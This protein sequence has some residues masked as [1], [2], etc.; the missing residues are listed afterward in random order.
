MIHNKDVT[1]FLFQVAETKDEQLEAN[2]EQLDS[3]I[4][5]KMVTCTCKVSK[6]SDTRNLGCNLLKIQTI[7]Y[8][9]VTLNSLLSYY[10]SY[11]LRY[12]HCGLS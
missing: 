3:D 1:L 4:D 8:I 9:S 11:V 2:D 6:F 5:L 7:I 10:F 12:L